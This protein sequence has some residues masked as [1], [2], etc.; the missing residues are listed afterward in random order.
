MTFIANDLMLKWFVCFRFFCSMLILNRDIDYSSDCGKAL[1]VLFTNLWCL[2][3]WKILIMCTRDT[4]THR[5]C[6]AQVG[7]II[8][9]AWLSES[10]QNDSKSSE[11]RQSKWCRLWNCD[12]LTLVELA[13]C[14]F[15]LDNLNFFSNGKYYWWTHLCPIYHRIP[16]CGVWLSWTYIQNFINLKVK[17]MQKRIVNIVLA[18][19]EIV[20]PIVHNPIL[21]VDLFDKVS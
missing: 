2:L 4:Y 21:S 17:K 16:V 14:S 10:K 15:K 11:W 13:H 12:R 9:R 20:N 7:I 19:K 6:I 5:I 3:T 8:C 1:G 18:F